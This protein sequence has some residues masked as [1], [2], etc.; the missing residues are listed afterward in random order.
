MANTKVIK[1]QIK[2]VSNIK[3]ITKALEIV[4]TVKLQ[5]VKSKTEHYKEFMIEFLKLTHAINTQTNIFENNN[6]NHNKNKKEKHLIITTWT[7]KWLCGS[8]NNKLFKKIFSEENN[9]KKLTDIFCIWKKSLEFFTRS[10]FNIVGQFNI[11]DD[12]I[13][14]DLSDLFLFLKDAIE[15]NKYTTISIYFNYFKNAMTQIP[16]KLQLFPLD[17]KNINQFAEDID[18]NINELISD[19]IKKKEI[20][21]EP[22]A[23]ELATE[24]KKQLLQHMIY[25]AMLQNKTGEFASRMIAMKS[26]KDNSN[27][28]IKDLQLS[29][30]KARQ[31]A[32]TQ[33]ISEI[34]WAKM[35]I[36]N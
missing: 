4:A 21:L 23:D 19:D 24:I 11:K 26:A 33:E 10:N 35:A 12:F 1:N 2:S 8:L 22:T 30:N 5:K 31:W 27:S 15:K 9:N 20:I 29:F 34:V 17:K 6:Q 7:D 18:I 32:I 36:E 16:I 3:Q 25:W 28:L 13:E 14:D